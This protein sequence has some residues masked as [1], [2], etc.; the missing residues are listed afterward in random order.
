MAV[1]EKEQI[2]LCAWQ[3]YHHSG[4]LRRRHCATGEEHLVDTSTTRQEDADSPC[5]QSLPTHS[6][7]F[8]VLCLPRS[9]RILT[10]RFP[11]CK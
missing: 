7:H 11:I 2:P 9:R 8:P 3:D 6:F 4:M 5:S 1:S 10:A